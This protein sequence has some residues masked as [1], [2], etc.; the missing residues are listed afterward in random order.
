MPRK[1]RRTKLQARRPTWRDVTPRE[2]LDF[3]GGWSPPTREL[4]RLEL[5][6]QHRIE[7]DWNTW[8][9]YLGHWAEVREDGLEDWKERRAFH[10]AHGRAEVAR[11][12][13]EKVKA[14]DEAE[15][16]QRHAQELYEQAVERL[17]AEER[18]TLPFAEIQYQRAVKGLPPLT[19]AEMRYEHPKLSSALESSRSWDAEAGEES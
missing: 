14:Q 15:H 8:D 7:C 9:D 4:P 19:S 17:A 6:T 11:R 13:A 2:M 10:L 5:L 3:W 16:W 18:K 1:R 12:E